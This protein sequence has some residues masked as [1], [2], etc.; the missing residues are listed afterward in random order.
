V[1]AVGNTRIYQIPRAAS[2]PALLTTSLPVHAPTMSMQ[3][4]LLLDA[5]VY[6]LPAV[7]EYAWNRLADSQVVAVLLWLL[8]CYALLALGLPPAMLVFGRWRDG[9]F[10]WARLIGLLLLGY[11]VWMP[12][13]LRLWRYDRLGL[14]LGVLLV[15]LLDAAVLTLRG[16]RL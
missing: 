2:D 3:Q 8:A 13:S 11:A 7:N 4:Q 14:A 16:R 10:A 6:Q 12:V 5:P 1:Y 15:L 9:G